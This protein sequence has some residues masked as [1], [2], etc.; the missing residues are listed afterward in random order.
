MT[1]QRCE[2]VGK[3]IPKP[4]ELLPYYIFPLED[5]GKSTDD[6][7]VWLCPTSLFNTMTLWQLYEDNEGRPSWTILREYSEYIRNLVERGREMR[8]RATS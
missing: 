7:T 1:T 3:H 5:G 8:R 2:C 4:T 6:N